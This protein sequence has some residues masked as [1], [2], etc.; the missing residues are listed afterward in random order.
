MP[1]ALGWRA[2]MA[3]IA[4]STN[5]VVEADFNR[6]CPPGVTVHVGRIH[7]RD[8]AMGDDDAM[9]NLIVQI[10][11]EIEAACERVLTCEPDYVV[12]GMSAE[13][14]WGGADGSAAFLERI[15]RI[16]GLPVSTGAAACQAA[17]ARYGARRIGVVT[18]YQPVGD[19][20]VVRFFSDIGYEI[21]ALE[22]LREN[23]NR[24]VQEQLAIEVAFMT[25]FRHL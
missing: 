3:V 14:F 2:A 25:A 15:E 18:P 23:F 7:I 16:V 17:L 5:T 6:M 12:M 19:Q 4:P 10:R 21:A 24:N 20:Q 11:A 22:G 8:Q 9:G 1:H 13:T